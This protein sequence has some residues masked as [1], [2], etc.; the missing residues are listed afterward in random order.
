MLKFVKRW[1]N[2][3]QNCIPGTVFHPSVLD[4][5]FL[6]H[7]KE[8]AKLSYVL[9][10]ECSSDPLIVELHHSLLTSDSQFISDAVCDALSAAKASVSNIHSATFAKAACCNL[11]SS[12]VSYWDSTFE[13]LTVQNKF[14]DIVDLEQA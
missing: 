12:H 10:I 3:P 9:T 4:L 5:P 2:L 6:P 11:R 13:S 14:L 7:F 1:L 8:C